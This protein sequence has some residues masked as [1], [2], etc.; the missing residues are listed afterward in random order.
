MKN[1][2]D[3]LRRNKLFGVLLAAEL[4]VLVSLIANLFGAPFKL[5]LTPTDFTNDHTEIAE[6]DDDG[7]RVWDQTESAAVATPTAVTFATNGQTLRSGAYEVTV[8]YFSCETPDA[9]TFSM[10]HSA[11]SLTFSSSMVP[12]AV[13]FDSLRLDD[14]HR[15]QTTRL[16]VGYGARMQDLT[17][18]LTYNGQG[19]LYLYSITLVEQPIY[20]LTRL[21]C[22]LVAFVFADAL[23][24][25]FFARLTPQG[26]ARCKALRL[27]LVLAGITA[28]A[29][30]PLF[31]NYLY[32]GHDLEYHLQRI[33]AMA[34]EMSYGQFPVRFTTT[35]LNN[36]GYA[37]PLCYCELFLLLPALLYNLWLPL[38]TCYQIYLFAVT[39]ATCLIAYFSFSK[40]SES[41]RLGVLGALL[42]T[43]ACYRLVCV[44]TRAAAGE[45][46]AMTFFP[47]VLLGLY[48]IYTK[49]KPRFA[50]WLPM[51]LGMAAM[52]QS[53]LLSC[54]LT[55]LLLIIFC[56]LRLRE[57]LRPARL[58]A[59]VKAALL[60]VGLS[61]W[62]LF[63]FFLS[64]SSIP[65]MVNGPLI[66]KIQFQGLYLMQLLSPFGPGFAGADAGT[67][68]DMTLSL[69]LPLVIGLALVV[70]QLFARRNTKSRTFTILY[71]ASG[72]FALTILLASHI[73]PWDYVQS[74][75]GRTA[76]KLAGLF[77]YPWR[78][79]SLAS[80]LLVLAILM[81]VRLLADRDRRLATVAAVVLGSA[82]LLMAG[83]MQTQMLLGQG[84][85]SW[86]VFATVMPSNSIGVGEY[87]IDGTSGYETIWAQ[88][89]PGSDDLHL[90]SYEKK[91]GV[92][93]LT[94]QNDGDEADISLPI[95]NYGNY[96][97]EDENG[98]PF[99]IQSG[100]NE[101]VVLTIPANYT[102][103][104]RV[105]YHAPDFWR[106][107]EA[108]SAVTL[109]GTIGYAAAQH[110]KRRAVAAE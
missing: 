12:S 80:V 71:T 32:F 7:L 20:R 99:T 50:D 28:F 45:H 101:R 31:S 60:A 68:P 44:Y 23:L 58:L 35:T 91:Q 109:L 14:C 54:E 17:A 65:F 52:V 73:F 49:E 8:R 41:R 88:P 51:A 107:F 100:E 104:I 27:P 66:G 24:L 4:V 39:L 21:L 2:S 26:R 53:H 30:L 96:Y 43:L 15:S 10:L 1:F 33:S 61:A 13:S 77:Q 102:G 85:Q 38:R 22:W 76:G 108:V 72:F 89:K 46:T 110:R 5:A 69:G 16:W 6:L 57:T 95:F 98:Q 19:Q 3:F 29:C 92:A 25:I 55:A 94:V 106:I 74:Y 93:Y 97:A 47:L 87:L 79:L 82:A 34:A 83:M 81:A 11:G 40:I 67:N 70:S 59:W 56:V 9:P 62:Y 37:N 42:Y 75:F 90:V 36:Y 63:P 48:N 18:K 103:T 84:E 64:T 78:F 86:N 105:W